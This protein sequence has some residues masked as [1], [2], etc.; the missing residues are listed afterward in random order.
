M[1]RDLAPKSMARYRD[2]LWEPVA[3]LLRYR[4]V[5]KSGKVDYGQGHINLHLEKHA[6]HAAVRLYNFL[7]N[8]SSEEEIPRDIL[9][10][11]VHQV[12]VCLLTSQAPSSE[13]IGGLFDLVMALKSYMGPDQGFGPPSIA[14][15][16]CAMLQYGLRTIVIHIARLGGIENA[17]KILEL[18][19]AVPTTELTQ[20]LLE[21][22]L[23]LD[24]DVEV[25]PRADLENCDPLDIGEGELNQLVESEME[26][27]P[28]AYSR[29]T[30]PSL[31][32]D[33]LLRVPA[34]TLTERILDPFLLDTGDEENE[35]NGKELE[36]SEVF[37]SMK[38]DDLLA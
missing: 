19:V 15:S 21:Q 25:T 33:P 22:T 24:E 16:Y 20:Q 28:T 30:T 5:L 31:L 27:A 18:P 36:G 6:T 13:R 7:V 17:F 1:Y 32:E 35:A 4:L 34:L 2:S 38:K 11:H 10:V 14:S 26:L 12:L 9:A 37:I 29:R 3:L 8:I 23:L